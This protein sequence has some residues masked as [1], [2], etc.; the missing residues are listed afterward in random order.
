MNSK[1]I[2]NPKHFVELIDQLKQMESLFKGMEDN[3]I[4][5]RISKHDV[6]VR[7]ELNDL[8]IIWRRFL[9]ERQELISQ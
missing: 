9:K 4:V 3:D 8:D 2:Y 5:M 1:D 7:G 6:L